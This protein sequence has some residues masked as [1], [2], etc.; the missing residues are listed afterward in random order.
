MDNKQLTDLGLGGLDRITRRFR[1]VTYLI[2]VLIVVLA[3]SLVGRAWSPKIAAA[4]EKASVYVMMVGLILLA[5]VHRHSLRETRSD[6]VEK[7]RFLATHDGLTQVY[8]LHYLNERIEQEIYRSQ[9]FSHSFSLLFIDLDGFKGVND[10]HGHQT[11]DKVLTT[12]AEALR[13]VCRL[14]DLVGRVPG[15]VGR[16]G[17]DEFVVLMPETDGAAAHEPAQRFIRTV[18]ELSIEI[19]EGVQIDTLGLSLGIATY[20]NDAKDGNALIEEADAAMYRAKQAGGNCFADSSGG[21]FR[22]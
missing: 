11:G 15:V 1:R 8:N 3:A 7:I 21:V 19:G 13:H 18:Q 14:T 12:V 9:R 4:S 20:P 17:G 22:S 5:V 2:N 10:T 16:V 6:D